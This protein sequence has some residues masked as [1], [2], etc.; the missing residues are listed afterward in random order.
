MSNSESD[1]SDIIGYNLNDSFLNEIIDKNKYTI[2][3]SKFTDHDTNKETPPPQS[4]DG[5]HFNFFSSPEVEKQS[6]K[7][8]LLVK[9][10]KQ[11]KDNPSNLNSLLAIF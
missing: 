2:Q 7:K 3:D 10:D 4:C 8:S 11:L 5:K 6:S 1:D 9:E